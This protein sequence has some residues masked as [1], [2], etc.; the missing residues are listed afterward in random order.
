MTIATRACG[1]KGLAAI[2][3]DN[4]SQRWVDRLGL[5]LTAALVAVLPIATALA[6]VESL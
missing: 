3:P 6:L 2:N 1:H 4:Q 5:A